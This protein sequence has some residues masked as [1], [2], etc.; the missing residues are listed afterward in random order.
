MYSLFPATNNR[1]VSSL[2]GK[3]QHPFVW[4]FSGFYKFVPLF[5]KYGSVLSK[6]FLG[7]GKKTK[8]LNMENCERKIIG[9]QYRQPI[10]VRI[11]SSTFHH[12]VD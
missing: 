6:I 7:L 9:V 12:K 1:D 11:F 2:E 4:E 10:D 8:Q 3:M 5:L